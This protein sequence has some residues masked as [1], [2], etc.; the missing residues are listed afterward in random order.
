MCPITYDIQDEQSHWSNR[1]AFS[2]RE[3]P[4]ESH[5]DRSDAAD[6]LSRSWHLY[7]HRM[8]AHYR[9]ERTALDDR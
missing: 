5:I 6:S 8:E 9:G 4:S 1:F 2:N 7:D 3:E